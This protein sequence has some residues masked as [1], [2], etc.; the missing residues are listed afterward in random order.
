[1]KLDRRWFQ[2]SLRSVLVAIT[3][4]G[5]WLGWKA[6]RAHRQ[7][8]AV[9]RI[10][11]LGGTVQYDWQPGRAYFAFADGTLEKVTS[12]GAQRD[13]PGR[14]AKFIG[15]EYFQAVRAVELRSAV[16]FLEARSGGGESTRAYVPIDPG[17]TADECLRSL[18]PQL[19]RLPELRQIFVEM[20]L[21]ASGDRRNL[22]SDEALA[23]LE[24]ALPNC[25]VV[26]VLP[27]FGGP[28]DT[29]F[30][31]TNIIRVN[32]KRPSDGGAR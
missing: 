13:E 17:R 6:E 19:Q 8:E 5:L 21:D 26:R 14:W 22:F 24:A 9:R 25:R 11:A 30:I 29:T 10:E 28:S 23:A 12:A 31:Q 32:G 27:G 4:L 3:A 1:M 2:V 15:A 16:P 18:V 7:R 20:P